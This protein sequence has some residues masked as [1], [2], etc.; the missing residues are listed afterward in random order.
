MET[1]SERLIFALQ[2][3][4]VSQAELARKLKVKPQVVNFLCKSK[5]LKSKLTYDIADILGVSGEWLA[6]GSGSLKENEKPDI[7]LINAHNKVPILDKLCLRKMINANIF[8]FTYEERDGVDFLLTVTDVG[9]KGFAIKQ[10]DKSMYPRFDEDTMLIINS[11]KYP[12]HH[13][14]A[15]VYIESINDIILR[16]INYEES[17]IILNPLNHNMF[18]EINLSKVDL[19]I[20]TLVEARWQI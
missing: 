15:L 20:G 14:F 9:T 4:K 7:K 18:K 8:S 3:L 6:R 11:D 16:Q 10:C 5:T 13:E 17:N 2:E 12:K 1:L 19:I